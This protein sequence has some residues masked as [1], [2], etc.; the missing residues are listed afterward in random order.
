MTPSLLL[1]SCVLLA[2]CAETQLPSSKIVS[3]DA[4]TAEANVAEALSSSAEAML[5]G[6]D[7]GAEPEDPPSPHV[8]LEGERIE[9]PISNRVSIAGRSM[10]LRP[11]HD[12]L[13]LTYVH[14][15]FSEE[16]IERMTALADARDGWKRSP[17]K[18]Q[19]SGD[20]V[21][22]DRRNSSSCP[23]LWPLMYA[24][25]LEQ[26]EAHPQ[27]PSLLE[28]LKLVGRITARV[29]ELFTA[30]GMSITPEH[31]EPLQLVKY[32][33]TE[34]FGPHHDYHELD[35][36]TGAPSE[37]SVQGEQRVFTVLLFG[38]TLPADAAGETHFP[39]LGLRVS[40]R[41]GDA[42]VW[43]NVDDDG[44]PNVRSLHEGRPPAD[45]YSKLAVNC[46]IADKPF[47]VG[48]GLEKAV[49]S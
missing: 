30:T 48:A 17:L 47:S 19:Q 37:S 26:L 43:A 18:A 21:K 28:E 29:A 27:G 34:T 23:L 22:S 42:L 12:E 3:V 49:R 46:W 4:A 24:G 32:A 9:R 2:V 1:A 36:E 5:R 31:I 6:G 16:E 20:A 45:G 33:P 25:K 35:P 7:D 40:P 8:V 10:Q 14:N 44:L 13:Q 39:M 11:L 41:M 15:L 38:A